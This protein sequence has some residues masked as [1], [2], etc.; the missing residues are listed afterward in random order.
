MAEYSGFFNAK[1][2][3]TGGYDREYDAEQFADYFSRFIS[4]GVFGNP[5]NNLQIVYMD[6]SEKPF[7]VTIKKGSAFIEG[8][9]YELTEDMEVEIP[10]NTQATQAMHTICCTLDKQERKVYIRLRENVVSDL[11][12]RTENVFDLVLSRITVQSNASKLNA[13]DI[14]DRRANND[15]CGFVVGLV[16]QIDTTDLFNQYDSAFNEW[17]Q[18]VKDQLTED[19]AGNLQNQIDGIKTDV[20][21]NKTGIKTLDNSFIETTSE[22][23]SNT[24]QKKI[25]SALAVKGL[26]DYTPMIP[27]RGYSGDMNN[28]P[29]GTFLCELAKCTNAPSYPMGMWA[30]VIC[31]AG[32]S[33]TAIFYNGNNYPPVIA[34]RTYANNAWTAWAEQAQGFDFASVRING[35]I[36]NALQVDLTNPYADVNK[37]RYVDRAKSAT[38]MPTNCQWGI[39]EVCQ[40][41]SNWVMVR[42]TGWSTDSQYAMWT[43]VYVNSKWQGWD[44][45]SKSEPHVL[46][47]GTGTFDAPT[48]TLNK[49]ISFFKY[50]EIIYEVESGN[51]TVRSTGKIM[52]G[53]GATLDG[54]NTKGLLMRRSTNAPSGT[55]LKLNSGGYFASVNSSAS[56]Y[57]GACCP[58][59]IIG[60]I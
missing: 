11:P 19:A 14:V 32:F 52:I 33:Q 41:T 2:L 37:P 30:H 6:N 7:N 45:F 59:R 5:A 1:E 12:E 60:Y 3:D 47:T 28:M 51:N 24:E 46:W 40:I 34:T 55:S 56:P 22:V 25:A 36:S 50:Y 8:Y 21:T 44:R 4:N 13:S 42:I 9:W 26:V 57:S 49:N 15:Y 20:E 53:N 17:F 27:L 29:T 48:L 43:N 58:R 31:Y 39:R 10:A 38:N 54:I 16:S 35:L 18:K 23:L